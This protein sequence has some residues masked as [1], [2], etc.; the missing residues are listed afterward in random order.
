[1]PFWRCYYHIVWA[2]KGRESAI[3][4]TVE[5]VVFRAV[6]LK[7]R[8][9]GSWV[10]AI[11]A[12]VDHVHVAVSIPPTL[13]IADW[14]KHVKG[15][16]SREVNESLADT[17]TQ[18]RWQRGYGALTVGERGLALVVDY[19]QRQK[20]HHANGTVYVALEDIGE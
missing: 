9:I 1:M 16:S 20:E 10:L 5:K 7:S 13:S 18:F 15:V 2:T 3:T 12:M 17:Q 19:V 11:N 14:T 6:E 8:E 4:S